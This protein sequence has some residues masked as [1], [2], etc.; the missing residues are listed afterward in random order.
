MIKE[1]RKKKTD[2]FA[3]TVVSGFV[4]YTYTRSARSNQVAEDKLESTKTNLLLM[5]C[6]M[7]WCQ[8]FEIQIKE[9]KVCKEYASMTWT[10]KDTQ[11]NEEWI[12]L[13]CSKTSGEG[14]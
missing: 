5:I 13:I 4:L 2:I 7:N 10:E 8:H 12:N 3:S 1:S 14:S 9:K 6:L 11:I